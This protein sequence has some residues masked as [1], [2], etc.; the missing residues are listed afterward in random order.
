MLKISKQQGKLKWAKNLLNLKTI[1][2]VLEF[3]FP[4]KPHLSGFGAIQDRLLEIGSGVQVH[5][6]LLNASG[7]IGSNVPDLIARP[8]SAAAHYTGLA[9]LLS[10]VGQTS[11]P[12]VAVLDGLVSGGALGVGVHASACVVTERTRLCL[13]GPQYGFVN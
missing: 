5:T 2:S 8:G 7:T 1:P 10:V 3:G 13:P 6:A 4:R 9:S 11:L 12:T